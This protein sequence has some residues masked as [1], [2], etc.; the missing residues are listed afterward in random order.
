MWEKFILLAGTGGVLAL[1][2]LTL[3]PIR[4]SDTMRELFLGAIR[5]AEAVG[6]ALGIAMAPNILES[7]WQSMLQLPRDAR[8]SMRQDVVAGRRL[9]LESLNG[10]IVRLGGELGVPTP[11]NFAIYAGL[12]A[13]GNGPPEEPKV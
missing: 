9:E 12:E 13:Y 11:L 7:H 10:A 8:S 1:T 3:G 4:D 2:R 5:E 6:R